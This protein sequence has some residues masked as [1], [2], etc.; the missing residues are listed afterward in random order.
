MAIQIVTD[1]TSD[2]P[3]SLQKQYG[4]HL[5]PLQVLFGEH[6]YLDGVNLSKE[7]FYT[8]LQDSS[9]LPTTSQPT[10]EAFRALFAPM[11]E[12]GD[13]VIAIL[14]SSTLSGTVQSAQI[15]K[16]LLGSD[17]IHIVD[18]RTVTVALSLLVLEAVRLRDRGLSCQEIVETLEALKGRVAI[19]ATV[20]TLKYLKMGG[21]L[22]AS[23]AII[24]EL[25][26][27]RPVVSVVDGQVKA[28]GKVRGQRAA[29]QWI[30]KRLQE[31][32]YDPAYPP[33]F[34]HSGA[35]ELG[36]E[37]RRFLSQA[38]PLKGAPL[39]EIGAVVGTHAGPGATGIAYVARKGYSEI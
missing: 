5:I 19:Y 16:E 25:L 37:L 36:E 17:R 31:V 15:A 22:S 38:Y 28:V 11:V 7:E 10:P 8:K 13:E 6:A 33:I 24:G 26:N 30:A 3:L 14:L 23:T 39:M 34:A 18:S 27:I 9:T 1:S 21:R 29:F 2:L 20:G 32:P 12:R 4:I 35:P